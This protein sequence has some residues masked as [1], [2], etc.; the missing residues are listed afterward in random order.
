MFNHKPHRHCA[1]FYCGNFQL[2]NAKSFSKFGPFFQALQSSKSKAFPVFVTLCTNFK[3]F[4]LEK[5]N[6]PV[7]DIQTNKSTNSEVDHDI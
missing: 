4:E 5:P 1:L 7:C 2:R 6:K 3:S